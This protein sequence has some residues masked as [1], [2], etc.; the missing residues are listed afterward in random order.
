VVQKITSS[1]YVLLEYLKIMKIHKS[2]YIKI[3][4]TIITRLRILD[5]WGKGS[6]YIVVLKSGFPPE[7]MDKVKKVLEG[8]VK[9]QLIM[10]KK[11]EH[12]WKYFLNKERQDKIKD[13]CKEIGGKSLILFLI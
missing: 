9:Q 8:L 11:K 13:I 7:Q 10:K 1:L 12:G 6:V 3:S 5:C 2:E 4:R